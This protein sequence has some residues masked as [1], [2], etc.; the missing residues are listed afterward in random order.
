MR[1]ADPAS[2]GE[3]R[4][5]FYPAGR[6]PIAWTD[7]VRP[8]S[9]LRIGEPQPEVATTAP[10]SPPAAEKAP[11]GPASV[12]EPHMPGLLRPADFRPLH[13]TSA[14]TVIESFE[15]PVL[16]I[17]AVVTGLPAMC[18]EAAGLVYDAVLKNC[19]HGQLGPNAPSLQR[20]FSVR[21]LSDEEAAALEGRPA[22]PPPVCEGEQSY[23]S[24]FFKM[25]KPVTALVTTVA[26]RGPAEER[27][28][29]VEHEVGPHAD[30][31]TAGLLFPAMLQAA[32]E[33]SGV[34]IDVSKLPHGGAE[35]SQAAETQPAGQDAEEKE[36]EDEEEEEEKEDEDEEE[37]SPGEQSFYDILFGAA[38]SPQDSGEGGYA[39][40]PEAGAEEAGA[41]AEGP[42]G[43][44]PAGE[45]AL[46]LEAALL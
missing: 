41:A 44:V 5:T 17:G 22:P 25:F 4:V 15:R 28:V 7:N 36:E 40:A 35:D 13:D 24:D 3:S 14:T 32:A 16:E 23:L 45:G 26:L 34:D 31:V 6:S 20:P 46:P 10:P 43:A 30:G 39:E 11:E 2:S 12:S 1:D 38:A 37:E 27:L 42:E 21:I 29:S 18:F 8:P 9:E 33:A 19:A